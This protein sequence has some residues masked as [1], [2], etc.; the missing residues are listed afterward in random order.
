MPAAGPC[1]GGRLAVI[2]TAGVL[3]AHLAGCARL[4][5]RTQETIERPVR[6]S[7]VA[8][9]LGGRPTTVKWLDP[10]TSPDESSSIRFHTIAAASSGFWL[11]AANVLLHIPQDGSAAELYE[12]PQLVP[13]GVAE[14]APHHLWVVGFAGAGRVPWPEIAEW[15]A[16]DWRNATPEE[17]EL[18][19][20]ELRAIVAPAP[21]EAWAVGTDT[22]GPSR[23][24]IVRYF[25]GSWRTVPTELLGEGTLVAVSFA[26]RSCGW[27]VGR[28]KRGDAFAVRFDGE[29]WQLVPGVVLPTTPRTV[30]A[31]SCDEAWFGG[32]GLT[33]Y[34]EG[35]SQKIELPRGVRLTGLAGCGGGDTLAVGARWSR[36]PGKEPTPTG[37]AF[38]LRAGH[39]DGLDIDMPFSIPHWTFGGVACR[40]SSAW[41][42]GSTWTTGGKATRVDTPL[43]F[44]V[45]D[46]VC[47]YRGWEVSWTYY[48][49]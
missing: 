14:V 9:G 32:D 40:G 15:N 18:G 39:P 38:R 27:A 6:S 5:A 11:S 24:A 10:V 37:V 2:A 46:R 7:L 3:A 49:Q 36:E 45:E 22:S 1:R 29:R 34:V 28:R 33:H 19:T 43:L 25:A 26:G 41:A 44:S 35:A 4:W 16:G 30:S 20:I 21:D 13:R 31:V 23:P 47:R 12:G 48:L 8:A 17:L 42:F